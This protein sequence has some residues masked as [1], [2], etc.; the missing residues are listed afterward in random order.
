MF[1]SAKEPMPM[2]CAGT[3]YLF[4]LILSMCYVLVIGLIVFARIITRLVKQRRCRLDMATGFEVLP[5]KR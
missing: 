1:S 5:P 4:S 3:F 2:S